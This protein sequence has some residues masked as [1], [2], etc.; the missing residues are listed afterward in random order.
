MVFGWGKKKQEERPVEA[1]PQEKEIL[2]ADVP[3]ITTELDQLRKS[4]TISEIKHLRNNTEPLIDD[5]MKIGHVLEKDDLKVDDVDKHLAIIVIRGKKQVIDV[6]KKDVV[7]LLEIS[8]IDDARKLHSTLSQILKKVGDVLGR[9]TRVIHIFAKK[10]AS[11]LKENLE[12]MNTNYTEI[13]KLLKN[14][15]STRSTADDITDALNKIEI[16]RKTRLEKIKK[17]KDTKQ[18]IE[19]LCEKI[20]LIQNSIEEI[21]T[22]DNYKKYLD[23]K[24][25]LDAFTSQKSK[26]KND[27]DTQFTKISRPLSRYEYGSSLD[28]EQKNL[29]T[30]LVGDPFDVLLSSNKDSIIV[31]LEN[32]RKGI[33]SGSISVKDVDKSMSQ[34]TETEESLDGFVKRVSEY[35]EKYEKMKN[36]L[37]S[38]NPDEL[39]S[40]ENKLAKNTSFKEDLDLKSETF[41]GEIDEIDSKIPQ[42]VSEIEIKLREFSNTKYTVLS[43]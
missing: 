40:L 23:L 32:V 34:I 26:I 5:L 4:Q 25:T 10:Y 28:K 29:L 17:I 27:I 12:V 16:L 18:N 24:N 14:Y 15:D 30:K 33:S 19:S 6:I 13:Q 35:L 2:L 36:D 11:Q 41:Q 3:K 1:T 43:S 42:L 20:L 21:K 37:N 31:I 8:S 22:S 7:H 38:I 9:Q 39:V